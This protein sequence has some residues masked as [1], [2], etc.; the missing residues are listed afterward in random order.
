LVP[1]LSGEWSM[2]FPTLLLMCEGGN[3][4][5]YTLLN[6]SCGTEVLWTKAGDRRKSCVPRRKRA[7]GCACPTGG[8]GSFRKPC[9]DRGGSLSRIARCSYGGQGRRGH[10]PGCRDSPAKERRGCPGSNPNGK[11]AGACRGGK[12]SRA[13]YGGKTLRAGIVGAVRSR[14]ERLMV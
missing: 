10:S 13:G 5:P 6:F 1:L 2:D 7:C 8:A 12:G 3:P 9:S 11:G 4:N 14:I